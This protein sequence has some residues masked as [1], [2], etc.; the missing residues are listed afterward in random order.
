MALGPCLSQSLDMEIRLPGCNVSSMVCVWTKYGE[1][2]FYDN[3]ETDLIAKNL[4]KIKPV[5]MINMQSMVS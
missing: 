2:V 4:T 5:S 1:F 3:G